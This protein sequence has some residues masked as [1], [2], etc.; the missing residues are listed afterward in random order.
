MAYHAGAIAMLLAVSDFSML[1]ELDFVPFSS[2]HERL[3]KSLLRS[4][5]DQLLLVEAVAA[6][7]AASP[8]VSER[9]ATLIRVE[10][11]GTTLE[12]RRLDA[13]Q[14][15]EVVGSMTANPELRAFGAGSRLAFDWHGDLDL[16]S[17][18]TWYVSGN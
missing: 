6:S 15:N 1:R 10:E 7:D 11:S 12:A 14:R 8:A 5:V 17:T 16:E 18:D 9:Q 13:V 2:L 4:S 3:S